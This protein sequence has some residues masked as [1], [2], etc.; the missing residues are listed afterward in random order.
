MWELFFA[1]VIFYSIFLGLD[2]LLLAI[3]TS[4]GLVPYDSV[5]TFRCYNTWTLLL[6]PIIIIVCMI[7]RQW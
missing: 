6:L 5:D 3:I 1:V 4:F 7:L 2:I